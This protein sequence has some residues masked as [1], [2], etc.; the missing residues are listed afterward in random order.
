MRLCD[1]L[2]SVG[3]VARPGAGGRA[4][5]DAAGVALHRAPRS[6]GSEVDAPLFRPVSTALLGSVQLSVAN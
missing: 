4:V 2:R 5:R 3:A 1:G 6:G